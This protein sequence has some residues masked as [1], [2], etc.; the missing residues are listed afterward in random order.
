MF[1]RMLREVVQTRRQ[2]HFIVPSVFSV[3]SF[4]RY[5]RVCEPCGR[6]KFSGHQFQVLETPDKTYFLFNVHYILSCSLVHIDL[7]FLGHEYI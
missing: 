6:S 5:H 7:A 1:T 2:T 4:S 3:P